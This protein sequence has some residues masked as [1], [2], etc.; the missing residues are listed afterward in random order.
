MAS[1]AVENGDEGQ[2]KADAMNSSTSPYSEGDKVLIP[3]HS[4]IYEA[5]VSPLRSLCG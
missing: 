1:A 2:I 4:L 3:Q 5:K